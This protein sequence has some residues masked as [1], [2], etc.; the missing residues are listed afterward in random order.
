MRFAIYGSG[1]LGSYF[2]A[3]LAR[4]GHEVIFIARGAQLEAM[5]TK[6]LRVE[7]VDEA[8]SLPQVRVT[9]D[10]GRLSP[11]DFILVAVKTWQVEDTLPYLDSMLH[12]QT[13]VLTLQN[14]VE[15]HTRIAQRI[16]A[17]RV[18]AGIVRGFFFLD[19]PGVVRHLGVPPSITFGP[20]SPLA[21]A[22]CATLL[23][24][25]IQA[26]IPADIDAALWEKFLLVT[27]V[28]GVGAL[29]RMP[30][31]PIRAYGP[32]R[33]ML[34]DAMREIDTLARA[35]QVHLLDDVVERTMAFVDTFPEDA[36]ASMQRDLMEGRPSELEAQT[37]AV[38]RLAEASG[39]AVPLNRLIY[40]SLILQERQARSTD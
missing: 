1:A 17:E 12:Q 9:N 40:D 35:R 14:G 23:E 4:H 2:G 3:K 22:L 26:I 5:R 30:M 10:P 21:E 16:G 24:A 11:V 13:Q 8:F 31:G 6:G 18:L 32:T 34:E 25:G 39:V 27:A 15:L 20:S 33:Q 36:T 19:G 7:G 37:G 29:T 28:S 38:L